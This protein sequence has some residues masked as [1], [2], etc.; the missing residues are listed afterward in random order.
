MRLFVAGFKSQQSELA[1][2]AANIAGER[3]HSGF[4]TMFLAMVSVGLR[5]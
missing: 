2:I 4:L 1:W 3:S 5:T